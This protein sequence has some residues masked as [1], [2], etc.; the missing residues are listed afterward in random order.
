VSGLAA[1]ALV[2]CT[3]RGTSAPPA[4]TINV[5]TPAAT[6][7]QPQKGGVFKVAQVG[8]PDHFD[9][10]TATAAST[11]Q[12]GVWAYSRLH[13]WKPGDGKFASGE[14]EGDLLKSWEQP[15]PLRYIFHLRENVTWDQRAPTNGR[16]LQAKDVVLSWQKFEKSGRYRAD[17]A[18]SVNKAASVI[19]IKEID[20]K[21]LQ[22]DLKFPDVIALPSLSWQ[23]NFFVYPQ[24]SMNGGFDPKTDIRGTG[25]FML[26][27]HRPGV[28]YTFERS[29]KWHGPQGPW[30]DGVET[31]IIPAPAQWETQ[32]RSGNIHMGV[33]GK[34]NIP[35][36]AREMKNSKITLSPPPGYGGT[37]SLQ[38]QPGSPFHDIR[39]RKAMSMSI[40]RDAMLDLYNNPADYKAVGVNLNRY[41][42]TPVSPAYGEFWLNPQTP[43]F[44][45]GAAFLKYNPTEAQQ[46]LSAAGYNASKPFIFDIIEHPNSTEKRAETLQA[47]FAKSGIKA[48]VTPADYASEWQKYLS[49]SRGY[50]DWKTGRPAVMLKPNTPN[51]D[52]LH[53]LSRFLS[54]AGSLSVTGDVFPALTEM[55]AKARTNF[56]FKARV[57]AVHNI[58]RYAVENMVA[59]PY[60]AETEDVEIF[61]AGV[62][63]PERYQR[64]MGLENYGS[65][66][67]VIAPYYWL[68]K[69][70]RG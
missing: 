21:T 2:G 35:I 54:G 43:A 30:I 57:E 56:D 34:P 60:H 24:E 1:A 14:M 7:D 39:V 8:A 65:V 16:P 13:Q 23:N 44:G 26:T 36:V 17:I 61:N 47:M 62:H 25:P 59:P 69:S 66:S 68:D 52:V 48:N 29:P 15:D 22:M 45:P 9:I 58:Q 51:P 20:N 6:D 67:D 18:N 38:W 10:L 32:F 42:Y 37:V 46:L 11:L 53:W 64:W 19:A 33:G 4:K 28:G 50:F 41:W 31:T 55:I 12:A 3:G 5:A 63:G 70:L 40:D 49:N 27:K